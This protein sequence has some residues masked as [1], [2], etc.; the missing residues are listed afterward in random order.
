MKKLIKSAAT[1]IVAA[2]M[3][4]LLG[5][6][7]AAWINSGTEPVDPQRIETNLWREFE[8]DDVRNSLARSKPTFVLGCP[9]YH[10]ETGL[11]DLVLQRPEVVESLNRADIVCYRLDYDGWYDDKVDDLFSI[12]QRT[13]DPIAVFFDKSGQRHDLT[14]GAP[15]ELLDLLNATNEQDKQMGQTNKW[16]RPNSVR[17]GCC[18]VRF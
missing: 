6:L 7:A 1:K 4:L 14:P 10:V 3:V 12:S 2:M 18:H 16:V 5:L 8:I 15:Q 9:S 11:W 17:H 13:K